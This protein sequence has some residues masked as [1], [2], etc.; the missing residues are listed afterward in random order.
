MLDFSLPAAGPYSP[1]S[2]SEF[3]Y[4]WNKVES[5]KQTTKLYA[6]DDG[7]ERE[8]TADSRST[9]GCGLGESAE[10]IRGKRAARAGALAGG[11][12]WCCWGVVHGRSV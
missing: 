8:F 1:H 3:Q 6:C 10:A 5:L 2:Y 4:C 9:G 11:G 7:G 12:G